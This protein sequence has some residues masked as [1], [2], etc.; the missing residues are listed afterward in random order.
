MTQV[1]KLRPGNTPA[2]GIGLFAR[3]RIWLDARQRPCEGTQCEQRMA[4]PTSEAADPVRSDEPDRMPTALVL[5]FPIRGEALLVKLADQLRRNAANRVLD[6]DPFAF[7]LT[8]RP[9]SRLT[10]DRDA[11]VEF[12]PERATYHAVV[13][14][15]PDTTITIETTDFDTVVKFVAQYVTDRFSDAADVEAVS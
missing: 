11:Y 2:F 3:L 5:P 15:A 8:R 10:I 1:L 14:A 7:T 6:H 9:R 4:A 12:H 13:E